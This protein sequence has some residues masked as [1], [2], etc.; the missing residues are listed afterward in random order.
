MTPERDD[1]WL[2]QPV[3]HSTF[4][5]DQERSN[6]GS[7]NRISVTSYHPNTP[8]DYPLKNE[9]VVCA[10]G[11][12]ESDLDAQARALAGIGLHATTFT[13]PRQGLLRD[14]RSLLFASRKL[15]TNWRE[16]SGAIW[17]EHDLDH[18]QYI[19]TDM[20]S[21]QVADK[22]DRKTLLKGALSA[23]KSR[24]DNLIEVVTALNEDEERVDENREYGLHLVLHSL[25]SLDGVETAKAIPEQIRSMTLAGPAGLMIDDSLT[26]I[27]PRVGHAAIDERAEMFRNVRE[28]ARMAVNTAIFIGYNPVLTLYEAGYAGKGKIDKSLWDIMAV[29]H[30]P[31]VLVLGARDKMFPTDIVE[32]D[33]RMIPFAGKIILPDAGHNMTSHQTGEVATIVGNVALDRRNRRSGRLEANMENLLALRQHLRPQN[34]FTIDDLEGDL[35]KR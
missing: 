33:A 14:M 7:L 25:A 6:I 21:D 28:L 2:L 11:W 12:T 18:A 26:E 34:T 16:L 32:N 1:S 35:F 19:L 13:H 23:G 27:I 30:I 24:R 20:L 29:H 9:K 15:R 8:K 22:D 31:G 5:F 3:T 10:P 17:E 4:P